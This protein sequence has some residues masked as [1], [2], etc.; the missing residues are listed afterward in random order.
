MKEYAMSKIAKISLYHVKIPLDNTF[1]PSWVP[2][3]PQTDNRFDLVKIVTDD[4]VEGYSA[5]SSVNYEAKGLGHL[6]APYLIGQ[7]A[8]DMELLKDR[9]SEASNIGFPCYWMEPALWDIKG[10]LENKPVYE[11]FGQKAQPVELYAST[12]EVKEPQAR[13][14]ETQ[15]RYEEGFK[16]IKLRVHDFD[17]EK[18]IKQ[19]EA[20]C[21]AMGDK[22]KIGVDANQAWRFTAVSDAPIWDLERAKYFADACADLGVA[23]LEE[24]LPMYDFSDLAELT[25]YS[26]IPI[27]G[28]EMHT[29]G[30]PELKTMIERKC[31]DIFQPD[32][33]YCGGISR[34]L[35]VAKLCE[36]HGLIFT[37]HTWTNGIGFAVN[38]Q[39]ML[40]SGF[41]GK[42]PFE[43]PI[44]PPSW[45]V[46]K[47]DGLLTKPFHHNKG[48]LDPPT[49]PGLGITIDQSQLKKYGKRFFNIGNL[50]LM[51]SFV[52]DKG[53]K[54]SLE[55]DRKRKK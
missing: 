33:I 11:L 16:T 14:E 53:I 42:K 15:Q 24:P 25:S 26:K 52:W 32:A 20:V 55:V 23:W 54:T 47:R 37:P 19:V 44:N 13:V 29:H 1:Y 31:Y 22:M 10:K 35:E 49:G 9:M 3:Y 4:G 21:K 2:G 7:D 30:L 36:E 8:A 48:I 27:S 41:V 39:I 46:E 50:G 51:I 18:D 43:Y 40:A 5:R 38:L 6:V 34:C 28:G 12:G 45:V 17:V